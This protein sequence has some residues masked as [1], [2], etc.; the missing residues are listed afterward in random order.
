MWLRGADDG[1]E[2]GVVYAGEARSFPASQCAA[3]EAAVLEDLFV[4]R[5][6]GR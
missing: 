3:L 6:G 4:V 2:G 1:F 5:A